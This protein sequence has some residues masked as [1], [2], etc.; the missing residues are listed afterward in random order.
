MLLLLLEVDLLTNVI[1]LLLQYHLLAI[2]LFFFSGGGIAGGVANRRID[3]IW[4]GGNFDL[5]IRRRRRSRRRRRILDLLFSSWLLL[6]LYSLCVFAFASTFIKLLSDLFLVVVKV[7]LRLNVRSRSYCLRYCR[8]VMTVLLQCLIQQSLL[9]RF[10]LLSLVLFLRRLFLGRRHVIFALNFLR[11][12]FLFAQGYCSFAL[13]VV[14]FF[15]PVLN[16][17]STPRL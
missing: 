1:L 17:F 2:L 12:F 9:F 3:R 4:F 7:V 13:M 10:P 11:I 8:P 14:F 6:H 15:V 16:V 5:G